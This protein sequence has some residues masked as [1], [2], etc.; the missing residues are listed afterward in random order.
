MTAHPAIEEPAGRV[1]CWCC[2]QQQPESSV[3]RLGS[4]PEVAVCLR[5][6]HFL[7]Q[8]ARGREDALR[9]SPAGRV[10]DGLRA[11]RRF[12]IRRRW[13]QR[14]FIGPLLR[15]LGRHMP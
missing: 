2:G 5:C 3:V 13:H 10:R 15:R 12:V 14:P 8:Q 1:L 4:H 6:A 9:T 11:A 7:H